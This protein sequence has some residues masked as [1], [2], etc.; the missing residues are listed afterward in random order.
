M[1]TGSTRT[2]VA[3]RMVRQMEV[4]GKESELAAHCL[5]WHQDGAHGARFR[6]EPG[7]LEGAH[8]DVT[9]ETGNLAEGTIEVRLC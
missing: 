4:E 7:S 6:D 5:G 1:G 2:K 9:Q 3:S 8:P